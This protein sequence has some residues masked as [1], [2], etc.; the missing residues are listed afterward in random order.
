MNSERV[1]SDTLRAAFGPETL[2]SYYG[3][4]WVFVNEDADVFCIY[5]LYGT[6]RIRASRS[7]PDQAVAA[8]KCWVYEQLCACLSCTYKRESFIDF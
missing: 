5:S 3:A 2:G 8:F 6:W 1:S 7:T 4:Q